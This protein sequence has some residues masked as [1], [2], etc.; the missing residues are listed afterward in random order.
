MPFG[1]K[2][3]SIYMTA[4]VLSGGLLL[5]AMLSPAV[6]VG[7]VGGMALW[8]TTVV[9]SILT[10]RWADKTRKELRE[11]KGVPQPQ[12]QSTTAFVADVASDIA[13]IDMLDGSPGFTLFAMGV[14]AVT[15]PAT[16]PAY[17]IYE[18]FKGMKEL[19]QDFAKAARGEPYSQT[20]DLPKPAATLQPKMP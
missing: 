7:V 13:L 12:G 4:S 17:A 19:K 5:A 14:M 8:G 18:R 15:A 9:T 20:V 3:E 2:K 6:T 1:I 11:K 16:A 10:K